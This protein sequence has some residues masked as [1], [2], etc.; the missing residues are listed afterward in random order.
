MNV[1]RIEDIN[2]NPEK[3]SVSLHD[4]LTHENPNAARYQGLIQRQMQAYGDTFLPH[5]FSE[6]WTGDAS[7]FEEEGVRN[8]FAEKLQGGLLIDPGCSDSDAMRYTARLFKAKTYIGIDLGK[9]LD[10][11]VGYPPTDPRLRFMPSTNNPPCVELKVKADMLD[12]I[13]HL[14]DNSANF[15]VNGIDDSIILVAEYDE[16]FWNEIKRA[17]R[18]GGI[19]FGYESRLSH[20][21]AKGLQSKEKELGLRWPYFIYEKVV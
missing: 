11:Y 5:R 2:P 21:D 6:R 3:G 17:T 10:P 12:F 4:L 14:P 7:P 1:D 18:L 19:I 16:A 15:S 13:S 20:F 9:K 8:F